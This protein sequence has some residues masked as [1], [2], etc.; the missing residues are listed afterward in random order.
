MG[1]GGVSLSRVGVEEAL[2]VAAEGRRR[3]VEAGHPDAGERRSL[4]S[5]VGDG[6]DFPD[7]LRAN[8]QGRCSAAV[9]VRSNDADILS[10]S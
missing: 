4:R 9:Q 10:D 2:R 7:D 3:I 1:A 8:D 5:R 6:D